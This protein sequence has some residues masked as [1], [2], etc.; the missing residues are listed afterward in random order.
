MASNTEESSDFQKMTVFELKKYLVDRGITVNGYN[1]GALAEI[2]NSVRK[3]DIPCIHTMHDKVC[4]GKGNELF[5]DDMQ[6]GDP[7]K[8]TDLVNNFIDSPPFGLYGIFNFLICHSTA[9]DKQ[10]LAAY[11]SF[12]DYRLFEGGYVKSFLT[13]TLTNKRLHVYV[14]KVRPAMKTTTYDGEKCYDLWFILEGKVQAEVV[15]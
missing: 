7:F 9:Y 13:K 5:I 3:M 11:K 14:G 2:A 4:G 1:N 8:M 6:I 10:G 12:D 15:C